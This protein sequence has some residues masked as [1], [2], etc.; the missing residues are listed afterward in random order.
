MPDI[1]TIVNS[2][3]FVLN[4]EPPA[5]PERKRWRAGIRIYVKRGVVYG[6]ENPY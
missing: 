6:E 4:F 5:A 2:I 1:K 3:G